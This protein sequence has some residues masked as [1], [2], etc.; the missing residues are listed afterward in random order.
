MK[1]SHAIIIGGII[2]VIL[3]CYITV[4]F[5]AP[6]KNELKSYINDSQ[7][8]IA[9][10]TQQVNDNL[11]KLESANATINSLLSLTNS[12]QGENSVYRNESQTQFNNIINSLN[13]LSEQ[14]SINS[15]DI[16]YLTSQ[17]N[18]KVGVLDFNSLQALVNG[19]SNSINET[20]GNINNLK[21]TIDSIVNE[22]RGYGLSGK[23]RLIGAEDYAPTVA[24]DGNIFVLERFQCS[25][26]GILNA[27]RVRTTN[28]GGLKVALYSDNASTPYQIL[29]ANNYDTIVG[30][31]YTMINLSNVNLVAGKYYWLACIGATK[32]IGLMNSL[33]GVMLYQTGYAYSSFVFPLTFNGTGFISSTGI[34]LISGW[35][36]Y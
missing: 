32:C 10:L 18:G 5:I 35:T 9:V 8:Q 2:S 11:I 21:S 23:Y 25:Q 6:S 28:Y 15:N 13:G 19:Y 34:C 22:V 12:L 20:V 7:A 24:C 4:S 16:T 31:G 27:I 3:V 29:S 30:D 33:A 1:K 14:L 36:A 26:S 17:I